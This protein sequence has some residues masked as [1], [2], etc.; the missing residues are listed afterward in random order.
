MKN[1]YIITIIVILIIII[2]GWIIISNNQGSGAI[3]AGTDNGV[4]IN[5]VT[6]TSTQDTAQVSYTDQGFQPSSITIKQGQTVR[7]TNQSSGQMWVASNPHPTHTDYPGFDEKTAVPNGQ[8]YEFNFTK[9]GT[10]GY[11]NHFKPSAKG[12]IVVQ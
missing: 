8:F 12:E 1:K 10:W 11:H 5:E 7:F 4:D 6:S 3:N 9:I 2:A